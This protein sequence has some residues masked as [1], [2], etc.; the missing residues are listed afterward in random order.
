MKKLILLLLCLCVAA[1]GQTPQNGTATL[2]VGS[3]TV[4]FTLPPPP[5]IGPTLISSIACVDASG[6]A[7]TSLAY[8]QPGPNVAGDSATCTVTI[9]NAAPASGI[10]VT[11]FTS[12]VTPATVSITVTPSVLV[13]PAGATSAQFTVTRAPGT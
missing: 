10:T 1:V 2:T 12:V 11:P 6:N 3:Q 8:V 5:V 13:I 4:V 9:A 7:K